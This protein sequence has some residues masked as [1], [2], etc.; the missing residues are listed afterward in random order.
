LVFVELMKESWK[1]DEAKRRS[2][3]AADKKRAA[4]QPLPRQKMVR[5]HQVSADAW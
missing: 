4:E 2:T 1:L 3:G 5:A